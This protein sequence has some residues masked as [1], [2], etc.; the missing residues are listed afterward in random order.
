MQSQRSALSARYMY[1]G[2]QIPDATSP[3]R[4]VFVD[5]Q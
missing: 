5:P 2:A 4:F 1:R 3:W